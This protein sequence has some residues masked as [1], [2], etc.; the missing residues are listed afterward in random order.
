MLHEIFDLVAK[1][2]K[3]KDKIAVLHKHNS[4]V[5]RDVLRGAFDTT[6]TWNLPTGT[7][8]HKVD[9]APIG[10]NMSNVMRAGK[11]L[12]YFAKGGPGDKLTQFKRER[13]FIG[14]IESIHPKDAEIIVLMKDKKLGGKYNGLTKKLTREAFPNLILDK[15]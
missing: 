1:T 4:Q 12:K 11:Q 9:D 10:Y 8:P 7:P 6:I 13:M 2:D 5:L 14:M 3:R 15:D